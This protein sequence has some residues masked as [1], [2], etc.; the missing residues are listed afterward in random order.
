MASVR[1]RASGPP[2]VTSSN[3]VCS[4]MTLSRSPL[5]S[6]FWRWMWAELLSDIISCC[7]LQSF[8]SDSSSLRT[9]NILGTEGPDIYLGWHA[10]FWLVLSPWI[11]WITRTVQSGLTPECYAVWMIYKMESCWLILWGSLIGQH[12]HE[13]HECHLGK[14]ELIILNLA[15]L[16]TESSDEKPTWFHSSRSPAGSILPWPSPTPWRSFLATPGSPLPDPPDD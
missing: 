2:L 10:M 8:S 15:A 4:R 5:K 14:Y 9:Y 16:C 11:H 6:P 1:S 12:P 13:A 7:P 3:W